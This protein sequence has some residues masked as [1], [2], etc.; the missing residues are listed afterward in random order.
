MVFDEN[1][2]IVAFR[3]LEGLVILL[4]VIYGFH[5]SG[6]D[7]GELSTP[8]YEIPRIDFAVGA[9]SAF[10]G[11]DTIF[12][13]ITVRNDGDLLVRIETFNASCHYKAARIGDASLEAPVDIER[14]QEESLILV[15]EALNLEALIGIEEDEALDL[16]GVLRLEVQGIDVE[17][18]LS[19]TIQAKVVAEAVEAGDY[20]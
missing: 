15:L 4:P 2:Y 16:T 14:G 19:T 12:F 17:A 10:Q 5:A 11:D 7:L 20:A 6:W 9:V 3:I 8:I 1:R 18:S 13:N